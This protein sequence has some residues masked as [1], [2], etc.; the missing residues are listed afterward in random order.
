MKSYK[1]VEVILFSRYHFTNVRQKQLIRWI[2]T[3]LQA[4][5]ER[6]ER[7]AEKLFLE[8]LKDTPPIHMS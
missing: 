6:Q 2:G 5:I 7:I 3:T 1:R 4:E 8:T